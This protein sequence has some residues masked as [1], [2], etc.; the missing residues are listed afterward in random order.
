MAIELI[1]EAVLAGARQ[2]LACEILG[3]TCRTL[4][5]WRH[6]KDLTDQRTCQKPRDY[7]HALTAEEKASII[8]ISNRKEYKSLPPSQIVPRLADKGIYVASESSFYRVLKEHGQLHHRGRTQPPKERPLPAALRATRSNQL[9]SWD[10]TFLPLCIRGQFLRLY[11]VMDVYS[12]YIVSWE[13]HHEES[14]D[15]AAELIRKACLKHRIQRK[16]L[17]LHSDNGSP[18]KGATM[19][20]TL[21]RLGVMPSFSR[22]SVSDDNPYSEALFRTLKYTP[23]YPV[24]LP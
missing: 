8:E 18:M 16:Q 1:D 23:A 4:R 17:V 15:H 19:L 14:T 12:R 24:I 21:Q 3:L 5:R 22:P 13:V 9:W 6:L 10:I 11:M 7:P 2:A 20:S